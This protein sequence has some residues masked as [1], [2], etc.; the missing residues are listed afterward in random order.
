MYCKKKLYYL[1]CIG[2]YHVGPIRKCSVGPTIVL[3]NLKLI[4]IIKN[5]GGIPTNKNESLILH[6][7]IT[8][9]VY[10]VF[11]Y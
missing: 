5:I 11:T 10:N 3:N 9:L 6:N 8:V 4:I 7:V 1:Y 2:G